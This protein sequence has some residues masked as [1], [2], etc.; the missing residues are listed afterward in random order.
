MPFDSEQQELVDN[1]NKAFGSMGERV[2][3]VA[4]Y[5]LESD[6]YTRNPPYLFDIKGWK[7]WSMVKE[8]THEIPG[9]FPMFDLTLVGLVALNDPPRPGVD[10]SVLVCK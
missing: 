3:A 8:H 10:R 9:W 6:I 5:R 1:A 7:K 4:M 2:L